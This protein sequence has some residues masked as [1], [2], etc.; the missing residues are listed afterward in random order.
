MTADE[1]AALALE[2]LTITV[3]WVLIPLIMLGLVILA[4]SMVMRAEEGEQ[5]TAARAGGW[6]GLVL[7]FIYFL[8]SFQAFRAPGPGIEAGM[9]V[10]VWGILIG[11]GIGA[12]L[13][14]GLSTV[15]PGRIV[16]VVVLL[17]T[18]AGLTA[19]HSYIFLE[20]M[21]EFFV[22]GVLGTALGALLHMMV[23]PRSVEK[24][25]DEGQPSASEEIYRTAPSRTGSPQTGRS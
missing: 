23:F 15:A 7:F 21:S 19:F 17:L 13:L 14:W 4:R 12:F 8:H 3:V 16:G 22:A 25:A 20:V 18:F 6:A 1:I 2:I 11:A 9:P 10:D 5:L 24:P